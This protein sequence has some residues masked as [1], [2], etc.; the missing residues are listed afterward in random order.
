MAGWHHRLSLG[1]N[2]GSRGPARTA[3]VWS[4]SLYVFS[5][6]SS[7]EPSIGAIN[8]RRDQF[9]DHPQTTSSLFTPPSPTSPLLKPLN[10]QMFPDFIPLIPWNMVT[11]F[12]DGPLCMKIWNL[13]SLKYIVDQINNNLE[14]AFFLS[15]LPE[16]SRT[17]TFMLTYSKQSIFN[18]LSWSEKCSIFSIHFSMPSSRAASKVNFF[19]LDTR[20]TP[21]VSMDR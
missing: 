16:V 21:G 4:L 20:I 2:C 3:P 15:S 19:W 8:K 12:M 5:F 18:R 9:R 10:Y 1:V 11:S 13:A 17:M 7:D 6:S 14:G